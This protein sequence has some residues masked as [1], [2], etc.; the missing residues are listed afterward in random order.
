MASS[1]S[2]KHT[3]HK[4]IAQKFLAGVPARIMRP[5]LIF[6]L[7]TLILCMFGC[8]MVYSASSVTSLSEYGTATHYVQRQA[9]FMLGGWFAIGFIYLFPINFFSSKI[10]NVG[11]GVFTLALVYVLIG[12]EDAGGAVRWM[13]I[14]SFLFQPSEFA[15]IVILMVAARILASYRQ[16]E[17]D[18]REAALQALFAIGLPLFLIAREPD[19]GSVVI[20]LVALVIM[21]WVSGLNYG[22]AGVVLVLGI[23]GAA[24]VIAS[25]PYRLRRFLVAW[26][27]W[28]DPFGDGYQATLAIMAFASGGL[29]GRGIGNSTMKYNY[30]PEAHNDFILAIIGEECGFFGTLL[31]IGTF[32]ALC[33]TAV[34]IA[35]QCKDP[36]LRYFVIACSGLLVCQFL[37]NAMGIL[38]ITPM[39]GKTLPLISYGGSSVIST[40]CMIGLILR[41]SRDSNEKTEAD[42]RRDNLGFV[43]ANVVEM[44]VAREDFGV[45]EPTVR[46]SRSGAQAPRAPRPTTPPAPHGRTTQPS[47]RPRSSYEQSRQGISNSGYG[48]INLG[49]GAQDRLRP[50]S[51]PVRRDD[52]R[53]DSS[54]TSRDRGRRH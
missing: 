3:S 46:S 26:N 28:A 37:I 36:H 31:F 40:L 9:M 42:E 1:E 48:R 7:L 15:K 14:G 33:W 54:T 22:F 6:V 39:T 43:G 50:S 47:T 27:P 32:L 18:F 41:A 34:R 51:G 44:P 12:G 52:A 2:V 13:R 35:R 25:A 21:L 24:L 23:L 20:I 30:L 17:I 5:R 53:R 49:G 8:L 45:S 19:F 4:T 16:G 11:L 10:E 29:F 38:C